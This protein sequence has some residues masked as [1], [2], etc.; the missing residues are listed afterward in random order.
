MMDGCNWWRSR[1]LTPERQGPDVAISSFNEANTIWHKS[2][3]QFL[4]HSAESHRQRSDWELRNGR[5]AVCQIR[6][7]YQRHGWQT[8]R[9]RR[10]TDAELS[11][12]YIEN[13]V[14]SSGPR[15]WPDIRLCRQCVSG[16]KKPCFGAFCHPKFARHQRT[17]KY[18]V[19]FSSKTAAK[20]FCRLHSNLNVLALILLTR[21]ALSRKPFRQGLPVHPVFV[22]TIPQTIFCAR[23]KKIFL[24]SSLF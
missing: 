24:F 21:S 22:Q 8:I 20:R 5:V 12:T 23:F 1:P 2:G 11:Y 13:G 9:L 7:N 4:R 15:S 10:E 18:F 17:K 3:N 16:M 14:Q 6:S 19:M